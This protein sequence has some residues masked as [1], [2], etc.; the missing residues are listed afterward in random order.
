MYQA[1]GPVHLARMEEENKKV[2]A[3]P[4]GRADLLYKELETDHLLEHGSPRYNTEKTKQRLTRSRVA[5]DWCHSRHARCDRIFPCSR[6]L[7]NG[8]RCEVTRVR[9]KRG[10]PR[11]DILNTNDLDESDRPTNTDTLSPDA[12]LMP[13]STELS[14]Q[15]PESFQQDLCPII[16]MTALSPAIEDLPP[17][18]I[19]PWPTQGLG[20]KMASTEELL[21]AESIPSRLNDLP[22]LAGLDDASFPLELLNLETCTERDASTPPNL[23]TGVALT[24]CDIELSLRYPVLQ[25]LLPFIESTISPELACDLLELYFTSAY[26][27][28]VHPIC[29]H[30]PCYVL[31]KASF[32]G[33][34][35]RV[36]SP[37][38]LASILWVASADDHV[39]SLPISALY[40]KK[41]C[42]F[43]SSLTLGLL[44]PPTHSPLATHGT[45]NLGEIL[46]HVNVGSFLEPAPRSTTTVG[47]HTLELATGSLDDVIAYIHIA[48]IISV[49]K[50]KSLSMRWW[51]AAFTMARELKLNR[52]IETLRT[53]DNISLMD[54]FPDSYASSGQFMNCVCC[55]NHNSPFHATEEQREERRRVWW[56]LYMMDR[57]LAIYSNRPLM[58]L[59]SESKDLLLP[60]DEEAWQA[61]EIHSNSPNFNGPQCLVSGKYNM[62][63]VFPDF[64][65]H[66]PSIFGFYLPLMIIMG[67]FV[68]LYRMNNHPIYGSDVLG[69]ETWVTRLQEVRRQLIKYEVSLN[70]FTASALINTAAA[71]ASYCVH[72]FRILLNGKWD[73]VS[74]SED[75]YLWA[76]SPSLAFTIRHALRAADS[77]KKILDFD[78]DLRFMPDLFGTHLLQGSFRFLFIVESL[79]DKAGESSLSACE[80]MIRATET[81]FVIRKTEYQRIFCQVMRS[82]VAQAHGRPVNY[83]DIWRRH[84]AILALCKWTGAEAGLAL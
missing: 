63:R 71:Y 31:R 75:R 79:Q 51:Y 42:C 2:P 65:Y 13:P 39:L 36:C 61:G 60:L 19:I 78:P 15:S 84:R 3:G 25:P 40:R 57:H 59:D 28:H 1:A 23:G 45:P 68:D 6:C 8:T 14:A 58:L 12:P 48:F 35:Y 9:R 66:G 52:E 49:S 21:L 83:W 70:A 44:T 18:E 72:V 32:L 53:L 46:Y 47:T 34:S 30:L 73:P 80:V 62:R 24:L 76:S 41:I 74:L 69:E 16:D 17:I 82:A 50:Q 4:R 5:C 27:T 55:Q 54:S 81:S 56:L 64:T 11:E 20:T 33:E 7:R 77:V 29:Q 26:P 43:L 10:R 37:A 67:R 38:L 22:S